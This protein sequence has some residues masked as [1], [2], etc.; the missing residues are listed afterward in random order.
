MSGSVTIR[1]YLFTIVIAILMAFLIASGCVTPVPL[2]QSTEK[3]TLSPTA[4]PTP[5]DVLS[6]TPVPSTTS[7]YSPAGIWRTGE[8]YGI[9]GYLLDLQSSK[10]YHPESGLPRNGNEYNGHWM[11][12]MTAG[13]F[14]M[15]DIYN[16]GDSDYMQDVKGSYVIKDG[17]IT[18]T[19]RS[20]ISMNNGQWGASR[21]IPDNNY[22]LA[23][24]DKDTMVFD[25][26]TYVK[27]ADE[28]YY[29]PL[30]PSIS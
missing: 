1:L 14:R 6:T 20:V 2:P 15:L 4:K 3:P 23:F 8:A 26:S 25:G 30:T 12:F 17:S 18:L 9:P 19:N 22:D 21:P 24:V 28:Y 7:S 29:V 27:V 11:I 16:V 13:T 5:A 10:V